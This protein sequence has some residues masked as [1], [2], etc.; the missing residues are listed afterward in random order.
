MSRDITRTDP[1]AK[2]FTLCTPRFARS[3]PPPTEQ[4][5]IPVHLNRPG[6]HAEQVRRNEHAVVLGHGTR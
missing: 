5:R 3:S 6:N 2:V 1:K 4:Q